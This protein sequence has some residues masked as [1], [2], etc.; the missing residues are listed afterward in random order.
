MNH[1]FTITKQER[2]YLRELAKKQL[3]YA[4]LSIMNERKKLWYAHNAL[5]GEKPIIIMEMDTF[6]KDLLPPFKCQSKV[7]KEIEKNLLIQIINHELID[8][9]KV[10]PNYYTVNWKIHINE[11]DMKIERQHAQDA[12]GREIG[13]T[14]QHPIKDLSKDLSLLKHSTYNVDKELTYSWKAFVEEIIGDILPVKIKNDRLKWHVVP[15]RMVVDLMGLENMMYAMIDYPDELHRLY[16][17]I[18][19][20]I[21]NF[22]KWQEKEGI[23]CLNN[24]NDYAG[25]GSYGFTT[26]LPSNNYDKNHLVTTKDIWV[27]MNSQESVGISSSMYGEFIFPY[28]RD[29]AEEFGLVYYGCCESVH[30]IW[31]DYISKLPNL[32]KVSVSPWCDEEYMGQALKGQ[33]VIYSRKPSPNFVGVGKKLDEKAFRDH[34]SKTLLAAKSCNLEIIFRDIYTLSGDLSK[35]AKAVKITRELIEELW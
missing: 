13:F 16:Q 33:K 28:Y 5:K 11:F 4:N 10:I 31:E 3:E 17:F 9:D 1:T 20:D 7:A 12:E 27:N 22:I 2:S 19:D 24:E 32:R 34:I 35:A 15:S 21:L 6:K 23:L 14:Q 29:L 25:A 26:E 30:D 8:D 18:K